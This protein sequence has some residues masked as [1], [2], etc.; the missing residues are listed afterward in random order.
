MLLCMI[1]IIKSTQSEELHLVISLIFTQI[2]YTKILPALCIW[3]FTS[4]NTEWFSISFDISYIWDSFNQNGFS[5]KE[6]ILKGSYYLQSDEARD[7]SLGYGSHS[8][9]DL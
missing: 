8:F 6:K 7:L 4:S 2:Q 5:P 9:L 3:N 1:T